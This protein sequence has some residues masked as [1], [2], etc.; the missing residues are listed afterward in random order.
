MKHLF[1]FDS[2]V[3]YCQRKEMM[4][5][6]PRLVFLT[7]L[8]G[9]GKS[10]LALRLEHYLFHQGYKVFL[11]DGDNVRNGLNKDLSFTAED[12][13]ENIR[14]VGEVARLMLDA[15]LVVICAFISPYKEER[16]LVQEIVG[17]N[18]FTEVYVNCS[19]QV[20]EQRDTKGLYA[21]ARRGEIKNFT[22]IS[23][24]YESPLA[25][26][27]ELKTD[28]EAIEES[29]LKLIEVVEPQLKPQQRM[30]VLSQV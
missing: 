17:Q 8:S 1:P 6:E 23:A 18:R 13:K 4:Q 25:P 7:G 30:K 5:Q 12:R 19:L 28:Q 21:K 20:C 15:G 22:G 14:R 29:L 26:D 27:V 16:H 3:G 11:L 2:Q 10:T 9:S 24:P